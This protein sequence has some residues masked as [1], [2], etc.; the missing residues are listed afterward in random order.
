[1]AARQLPEVLDVQ[2]D[3]FHVGQYETYRHLLRE[4]PL[5][6]VRFYDGRELWMVNRYEDVQFV[7]RD[8]RF[9][10]DPTKFADLSFAVTA[11]V[12]DGMEDYF[13]RNMLRLDPPDHTRLRKLVSRG[14]TPRRIAE[15]RPRIKEIVDDLLCGLEEKGSSQPVDLMAEFAY[16]LP[17]AVICELLGIPKEDHDRFRDWTAIVVSND[18][19]VQE[20]K[21]D[22]YRGLMNFVLELIHERFH[23]PGN[24][25]LSALVQMRDNEDRLDDAELVSMVFL[26]LVAGVETT[27]NLIGTGAYLMLTHPEQAD[28]LRG[29]PDYMAGAVDEMLRYFAPVEITT[30]YVAEEVSFGGTVVPAGS[31]ILINLSAANRDPERFPQADTFDV[32]RGD[33]GH[34][35]FGSGVHFCLGA[36]LARLEGEIALDGLLRRFPELSMAVP[37]SELRWRRAFLR[38]LD[39]LPVR[40][41]GPACTTDTPTGSHAQ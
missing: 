19:E 41:H 29:K 7:L 14:F 22:S 5:A 1:M 38:G 24:D 20:L 2:D 37:E 3:L 30:R 32:A 17:V 35:T 4:R 34:L 8:G 21:P 23:H 13:Y 10:N 27:V 40:T 9:S 26:L 39:E 6:K 33:S 15:L 16:R 28:F 25:L 11:G 18:P 36:A 31:L 12:P